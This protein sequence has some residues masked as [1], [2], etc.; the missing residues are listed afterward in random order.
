M[1]VKVRRSWFTCTNETGPMNFL[2]F[3]KSFFIRVFSNE[4]TFFLNI[5]LDDHFVEIACLGKF[6]FLSCEPKRLS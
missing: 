2:K 6:L 1:K 4:E 3:L 5:G